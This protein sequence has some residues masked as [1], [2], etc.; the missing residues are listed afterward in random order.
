MFYGLAHLESEFHVHNLHKVV[1]LA[2]CF[3]AYLDP[4]DRTPAYANDTLVKFKDYGIYSING[5]NWARDLVKI[6]ENFDADTC[7]WYTALT[8]LD[9]QGQSVESEKHKTF[10]SIENRF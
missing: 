5:P 10:N 7:S 8:D 9:C 3:V 6:C 2:P 4:D 1:Q